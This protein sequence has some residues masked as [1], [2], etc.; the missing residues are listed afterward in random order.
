MYSILGDNRAAT[1]SSGELEKICEVY[2]D[3]FYR[4]KIQILYY[5]IAGTC[6]VIAA[7]III[8]VY[9]YIRTR[10]SFGREIQS[11]DKKKGDKSFQGRQPK[12]KTKANQTSER[13]QTRRG[14]LKAKKSPDIE[15]DK[16]LRT[17]DLPVGATITQAKV[18]GVANNEDVNIMDSEAAFLPPVQR[19]VYKTKSDSDRKHSPMNMIKPQQGPRGQILR[20][21]KD[22][23]ILEIL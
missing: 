3:E 9:I 14:K 2:L 22:D 8:V 16:K 20:G 5:V 19:V 6:V 13:T 7:L 11:E 1:K 17:L 18:M 21:S 10:N 23:E 12:D 15:D 4:R